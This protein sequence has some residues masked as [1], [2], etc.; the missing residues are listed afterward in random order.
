M[1]VYISIFTWCHYY[2]KNLLWL[3]EWLSNFSCAWDYFMKKVNQLL[4]IFTDEWAR[5]NSLNW[6]SRS[7][8]YMGTMIIDIIISKASLHMSSCHTRRKFFLSKKVFRCKKGLTKGISEHPVVK[9]SLWKQTCPF[10]EGFNN[11][12]TLKNMRVQKV[13]EIWN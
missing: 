1:I 10:V 5:R 2:F 13:E 11:N 3:R 8:S 12:F 4:T 6:S 9:V 7:L